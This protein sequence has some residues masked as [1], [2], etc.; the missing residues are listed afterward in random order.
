MNFKTKQVVLD[1]E[2]FKAL[3]S[4]SRVSIL[5]NLKK[6]RHTLS[7]LSKNLSLG[8]ST[9]K[10][11]C[12][13]LRRAELI[14]Q[15]DEGRK[16]K[17]YALT[18]KGRQVIAPSLYDDLQIL[19]TLCATVVITAG[20][21]FFLL[22]TMGSASMS[23]GTSSVSEEKMLT[24]DSLVSGA[25]TESAPTSITREP[26]YVAPVQDSNVFS[27]QEMMPIIG[28]VLLVGILIG[29]ISRKRK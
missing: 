10:E 1:E 15:F 8:N 16:W 22:G 4:E 28:A 21:L 6:R 26:D 19:I 27:V 12:D 24:Y 7:E 11:H 23:V 9:V 20:V 13:V 2:S 25:S 3:S 18:E 17:Y 5:K 29:W 14:E